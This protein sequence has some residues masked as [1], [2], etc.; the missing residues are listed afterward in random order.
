MVNQKIN[1]ST[2]KGFF[3]TSANVT[4]LHQAA[5]YGAA[6]TVQMLIKYKFNTNALNVHKET[7]LHKYGDSND[8]QGI[9]SCYAK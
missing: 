9:Y 3:H 6:K 8:M 2:K 7:P 1:A 5:L 4:P